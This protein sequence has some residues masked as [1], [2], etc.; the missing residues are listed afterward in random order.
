MIDL[1]TVL[2]VAL[3][4][5]IGGSCRYLIG[6][7]FVQRYGPGFP[8]G[9]LFINVSGSLLIGFVAELSQTRALGITP[10]VRIAL[11]TG[12]IGGY[13]TFSSY[14]FE[15]VTLS[16][17]GRRGIALLYALGS[18]VLGVGAYFVGTIVARL[19]TRTAA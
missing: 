13:T 5:A 18:I 17:E 19:L 1:R 14:I 9:T 4:S 12:L 2:A 3:G 10:F 8:L 6:V 11:A 15:A 7:W 16:G